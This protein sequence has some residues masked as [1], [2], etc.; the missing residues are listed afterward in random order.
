M[1]SCRYFGEGLLNC[2]M[3]ES[4]LSRNSASRMK[5]VGATRNQQKQ[6]I[7]YASPIH[8]VKINYSDLELG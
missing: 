8:Y 3:K 6:C 4:H 5:S 1:T 7:S 2:G